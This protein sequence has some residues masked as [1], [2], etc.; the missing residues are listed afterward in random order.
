MLCNFSFLVC[1]F[2]AYVANKR[3]YTGYIGKKTRPLCFTAGNLIDIDKIYTKFGK[4]QE[5]F[6][7]NMKS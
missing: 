6:I 3:F 2:S 1:I 4:N 7:L 5:S